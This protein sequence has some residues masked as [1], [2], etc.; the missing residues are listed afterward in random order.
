MLPRSRQGKYSNVLAAFLDG[1]Q[2]LNSH[3]QDMRVPH[4]I[5]S[6]LESH[7]FYT[8]V[9]LSLGSSVYRWNINRE[10]WDLY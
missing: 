6:V 1:S 3:G 7:S 9:V 5:K 10:S 2:T 4:H 8:V